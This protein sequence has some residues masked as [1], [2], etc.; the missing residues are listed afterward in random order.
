M[1][2]ATQG[3]RTT[4]SFEALRAPEATARR[5]RAERRGSALA[6]DRRCAA[7]PRG[8]HNPARAAAA[9]GEVRGGR[10]A[11]KGRGGGRAQRPGSGGRNP[12]SGCGTRVWEGE[13][14]AGS[15]LGEGRG[16]ATG[17]GGAG[18]RQRRDRG[19]CPAGLGAD[20]RRCG[21]RRALRPARERGPRGPGGGRRRRGQG[22]P[23]PSLLGLFPSDSSRRSSRCPRPLHLLLGLASLW[24]PRSQAVDPPFALSSGKRFPF[25]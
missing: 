4:E 16:G 15:R 12:G 25:P 19:V 14:G 17:A 3:V 1:V 8:A 23:G 13:P 5:L 9:A 10:A 18:C 6:P 7:G 24:S 2:L 20:R 21:D 11:R 22:R